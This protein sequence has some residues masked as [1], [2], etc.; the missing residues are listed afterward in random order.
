MKQ[1]NRV[2]VTGGTGFVGSRLVNELVAH[3]DNVSIV[4]RHPDQHRTARSGVDC[5]GWLPDL[6]RYGAIVHLAGESLFGERWNEAKKAAIRSSRVDRTRELV[7]AIGRSAVRPR[8]LVSASAIGFYG[9]RGDELLTEASPTGPGH[10]SELAVAWEREALRAESFGVRTVVLRIGV[11]LGRDGGAL[12]E[13]VPIFKLGIG[14]PVGNG[15]QW[16][17]WVHVRDVVGLILFALDRDGAR[18][19]LNSVAP[20]A[21]TNKDFSRALGR[22]LHRPALLPVPLFALRLRLGEL[23]LVIVESQR[24]APERA[25]ALGFQ[26]QFPEID[27]ALKDLVA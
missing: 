11:V 21:L 2:L 13:L 26:F 14:G 24:V 19:P 22:A 17:S 4:T 1:T 8:V 25:R 20:G 10:L 15:K 3:G 6:A 5:V 23:A 12:K 7:D 18:G 9:D 16:F 27:G